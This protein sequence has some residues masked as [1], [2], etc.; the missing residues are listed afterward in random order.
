MVEND[1]TDSA[2]PVNPNPVLLPGGM[3]TR[4]QV[5]DLTGVSP[6]TFKTWEKAGLKVYRAGTRE[7][8][9]FADDVMNIIRK[10]G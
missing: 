7:G 8:L 4:G 10:L 1:H 9:V 2:R 6:H 5:I 3:Y